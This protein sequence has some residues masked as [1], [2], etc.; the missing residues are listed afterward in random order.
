MKVF[1]TQCEHTLW[2]KSEEGARASWSGFVEHLKKCWFLKITPR[3]KLVG[4][5]LNGVKETQL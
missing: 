2:V 1:W 3:G 4:N 5:L